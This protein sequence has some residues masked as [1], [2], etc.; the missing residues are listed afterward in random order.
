METVY[1]ILVV[2]CLTGPQ[3]SDRCVAQVYPY[4]YST[5][6]ECN[7]AREAGGPTSSNVV[8][9]ESVCFPVSF[10]KEG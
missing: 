6:E 1:A 4:W 7:E 10:D 9:K 5:Q 8:V 3:I 2:L